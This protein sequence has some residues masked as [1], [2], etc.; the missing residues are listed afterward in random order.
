MSAKRASRCQI[1]VRGRLSRAI[2]ESFDGF[3]SRTEP[4][5]TVLEGT[6]ADTAALHGLLSRIE[7]LGLDLVEARIDPPE[8][9]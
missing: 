3:D 8:E 6:V 9:G 5:T 2:V 4:A 7:N 1:R